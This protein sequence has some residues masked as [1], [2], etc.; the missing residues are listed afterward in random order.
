MQVFFSA[1]DV[2]SI[3][4]ANCKAELVACAKMNL[5]GPLSEQLT[6]KAWLVA[7]I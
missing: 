3:Q 2:S 4:A 5:Q 6:V 1:S 7:L